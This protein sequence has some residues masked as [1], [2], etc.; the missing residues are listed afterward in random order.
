MNQFH[1][2]PA[3]ASGF[4]SLNATGLNNAAHTFEAAGDYGGAGRKHYE[5]LRLKIQASCRQ[6][7]ECFGEASIM[8]GRLDDAQ[9]VLENA[10]KIRSGK[11]RSESQFRLVSMS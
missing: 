5:A 10:D 8:M 6:H 11:L 4:K 7:Q 2:H 1:A 9:E 3:N